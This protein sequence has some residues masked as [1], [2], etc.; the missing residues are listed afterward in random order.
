MDMISGLKSSERTISEGRNM[1]YKEGMNFL[2]SARSID[3]QIKNKIYLIEALY[4]VIGLQGISYDKVSVI[5]SP[6][7]KFERVIADIDKEKRELEI[8]QMRKE[9]AIYEI[10]AK[11][12]RLE[13]SPEKTVLMGYF[14][15]CH[16]MK[17]IADD[18]GYEIHY[19][20]KLRTKGIEKL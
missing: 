17:D 10:K 8:L 13:D 1:D 15:R 14:I 3:L 11:I 9:K 19:A 16:K 7:N 4:T 6:E 2:S 12:D 20:Y 18:I 5:S